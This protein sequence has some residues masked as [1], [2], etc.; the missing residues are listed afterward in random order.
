MIF[1]QLSEFVFVGVVET[2][3]GVRPMWESLQIVPSPTVEAM[4][5]RAIYGTAVVRKERDDR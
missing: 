1:A 2:P 3:H 4:L 5:H